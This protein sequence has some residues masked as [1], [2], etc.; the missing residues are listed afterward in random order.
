MSFSLTAVFVR[1]LFA[2]MAAVFRLAL[3]EDDTDDKNT[4]AARA[5]ASSSDS[6]DDASK[7]RD[8]LE[9]IANEEARTWWRE[10]IGQSTASYDA[11]QEATTAWMLKVD[12]TMP[13]AQAS[14][15]AAT[16]CFGIDRDGDGQITYAEFAK[17][18]Q[19]LG[20]EYTV[21]KLR[22]YEVSR[23]D[24]QSEVDEEKLHEYAEYLGINVATETQLLWIAERCMRAPLPRGWEEFTDDDSGKTYFHNQAKSETSWEHPLDSHVRAIICSFCCYAV[25]QAVASNCALF[26]VVAA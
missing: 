22:E 13:H 21:S 20:S 14:I 11:V 7:E 26:Q 17:F 3:P 15:V 1:A 25:L 4:V 5:T 23:T 2:E 9:A 6:A 8:Y 24:S 12:S 19:D 10:Y 18:S 16:V